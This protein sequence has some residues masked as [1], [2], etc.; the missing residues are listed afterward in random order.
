M[1][2]PRL[3]I[4]KYRRDTG[5]E[6][7]ELMVEI[8]QEGSGFIFP[9]KTHRVVS[10]DYIEVQPPDWSLEYWT[11]PR[12]PYEILS[13][14]L[15]DKDVEKLIKIL[16]FAPLEGVVRDFLEKIVPK[17]GISNI[18]ASIKED[19]DDLSDVLFVEVFVKENDPKKIIKLWKKISTEIRNKI[20]KKFGEKSKE[21][22]R[23]LIIAV[24]PLR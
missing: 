19:P 23:K 21:Y 4:E 22:Q 7:A 16:K 1:I 2:D 5:P 12:S 14:H 17:Y 18:K 10:T 24:R 6:L 8:I 15:T 3:L 11:K 20:D 13:L 9:K